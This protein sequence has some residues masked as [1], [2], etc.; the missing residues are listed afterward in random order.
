MRLFQAMLV[1]GT[2]F[3]LTGVALATEVK[4][5]NYSNEPVFV[6]QAD[7]RGNSV[8]S[9]W[10]V[11]KPNETKTFTAPNSAEL[12]LRIQDKKGNAITFAKHKKFHDFPVHAERF[13]VNKESDDSSVWV[14]KSGANLQNSRNVKVGEKL[15]PGWSLRP[16]FEVGSGKQKLEIKP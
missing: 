6:A 5:E 8:S 1:V 7:K 13:S 2:F 10:T 9:G 11:V 15:L 4:V 3:G 12:Y 16:F 14:F